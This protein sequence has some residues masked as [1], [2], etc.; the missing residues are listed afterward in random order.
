MRGTRA[1]NE[2]STWRDARR[3]LV[4][5]GGGALGSYQA[6]VLEALA[7][8]DARLDWVTG[9][10]IGAVNAAIIVGNPP[11]RRVE[12]LRAFWE[13]VSAFTHWAPWMRSDLA[14]GFTNEASAFLAAVFGAPGLFAPRLVPFWAAQPGTP[15][16]LGIYDTTPL[17]NTL[18]RLVD[19][20]RIDDSRSP[21]LTIGAVE[22]E[23]GNSVIFDSRERT[24][25]PEHIMAS[26]ALPPGLPP[27]EIDGRLH[28]DGGLVSN[29]PLQFVLDAAD[30]DDLLVLQVDLFN[31]RGPRPKTLR[32][33]EERAKDIRF[34]S[35]TRMN[36]QM[37]QVAERARAA[38]RTL[39]A[40]LPP[41][42]ADR[43]DVALLR[44][45]SRERAVCV[46][47][48][49]YRK[50]SYEGGSAD[51]EFSRASMRDH[52]ADG[53][54]D[55]A[56]A[57]PRLMQ[58]LDQPRTPGVRSFDPGLPEDRAGEEAKSA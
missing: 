57:W 8:M 58:L 1:M 4:L 36:T 7:A 10:S 32:D 39:L 14:R 42:F 54:G 46:V 51:Y 21:R 18:E 12:R 43:G 24:I 45:L 37:H 6:G 55:V 27:V 28:L 52:W 30:Q 23:S 11:E 48:L 35:R 2:G 16:G 5:Q 20:D 15:A 38:T 50:R 34:S 26:A 56:A 44:D 3:V 40:D 31:A 49:I 25:G 19:F 22:V 53:A 41:A 33:L 47:Q 17:R 13:G 29:T 9:I